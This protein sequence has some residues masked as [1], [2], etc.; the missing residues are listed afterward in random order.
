[1]FMNR[2]FHALLSL[3][4]SLNTLI[5]VRSFGLLQEL[6]ELVHHVCFMLHK[7]MGIAIERDGWVLVTEDL[8]ERLYVHTTFK[9]A[10][11]KRMPQGMKALVR[12]FYFFEEQFKTS[13][14]R[15]DGNRLSVCRYRE[16][17]IAPFL[18]AFENRQ[19]LPRQRYHAA[20]SRRFRLVY[21]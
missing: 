6:S 21:D 9:G 10:G 16:E 20:G 5:H 2:V 15:T 3:I 1:M 19:Q 12:N 18:Y 11:G 4:C 13:L 17:R 7:G 8:G 14:V